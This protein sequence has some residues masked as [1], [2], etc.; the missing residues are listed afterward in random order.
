MLFLYIGCNKDEPDEK[1]EEMS[2]INEMV[3]PNTVL[4]VD[5][6]DYILKFT[7]VLLRASGYQVLTA[8]NGIRA[9]DIIRSGIVDLMV[10]DIIMPELDGITLIKQIR[11]FS[12][13]PIVVLSAA[14]SDQKRV[15]AIQKGADD[16][17]PKPFD[18]ERLVACIRTRLLLLEAHS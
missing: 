13:V 11:A 14:E 16:Y 4:L 8:T 18:P 5:D 1:W 6:E 9:L 15:D 17:F 12:K 3:K 2:S 7:S 10:T